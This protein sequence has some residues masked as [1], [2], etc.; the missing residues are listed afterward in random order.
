MRAHSG[1]R[2]PQSVRAERGACPP[3]NPGPSSRPHPPAPTG[4]ASRHLS[5]RVCSE[6]KL[7]SMRSRQTQAVRASGR[8][9][10]FTVSAFDQSEDVLISRNPAPYGGLWQPE[11]SQ[12]ARCCR[13][14]PPPAGALGDGRGSWGVNASELRSLGGPPHPLAPRPRAARPAPHSSAR[15]AS[16]GGAAHAAGGG[17]RSGRGLGVSGAA[18]GPER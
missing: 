11:A 1:T 17:G 8:Q 12:A 2:G 7:R 5:S 3:A 10:R 9:L 16:G 15:P 14:A 18:G 4:P 13:G 6:T